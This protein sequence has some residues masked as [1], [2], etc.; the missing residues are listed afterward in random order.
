MNGM[1]VTGLR[2]SPWSGCNGGDPW[3]AMESGMAIL[4][5]VVPDSAY[6]YTSGGGTLPNGMPN[7]ADPP[8]AGTCT[9][10]LGSVANSAAYPSRTA[11]WLAASPYGLSGEDVL[12]AMIQ[13]GPVSLSMDTAS[14]PNFDFYAGGVFSA[15]CT[16]PTQLS[17]NDHAVTLVGYGTDVTTG[18]PFWKIKNSWSS[19][20][21]EAGFFRIK[22]F[23][24]YAAGNK[25]GI[26]GIALSP[27]QPTFPANAP[28]PPPNPPS[29]PPSPPSPPPSPPP[30]AVPAGLA[31]VPCSTA[32]VSGVL[33]SGCTT[34]TSVMCGYYAKT[35]RTC[36]TTVPVF[37]LVAL[38]PNNPTF[39]LGVSLSYSP[40]M[41]GWYVGVPSSE[42][43]TENFGIRMPP[44]SGVAVAGA[45]ASL[46]TTTFVG[47][48][49]L[50]CFK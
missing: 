34:V 46:D 48:T 12:M 20:W 17:N 13:S 35:A 1:A 21:G 25:A 3:W 27:A 49:A 6:P 4:G 15:D 5:G 42:C 28:A 29:P 47:A 11:R 32:S 23:A 10:A 2:S 40:A 43:T 36:A 9:T 38:P 33:I 26:C 30:S 18:L 14:A 31:N 37:A 19:T 50:Q 7:G 16:S 24:Y 45:V 8:N 44:K 22:R 41:L 39:S